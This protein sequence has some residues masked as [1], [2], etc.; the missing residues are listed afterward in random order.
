M[1][2]ASISR[3]KSKRLL[4]LISSHFFFFILPFCYADFVF[5]SYYIFTGFLS[6]GTKQTHCIKFSTK[7]WRDWLQLCSI[8]IWMRIILYNEQKLYTHFCRSGLHCLIKRMCIK[9]CFYL[10]NDAVNSFL[11]LMVG[12]LKIFFRMPQNTKK[13]QCTGRLII[14]NKLKQKISRGEV[15]KFHEIFL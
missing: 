12:L 8:F 4:L 14:I 7:S 5:Y 9:S 1:L 3:W 11:F 2:C 6:S 15:N 10:C 13:D